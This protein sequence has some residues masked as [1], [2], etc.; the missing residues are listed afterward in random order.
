MARKEK[1]APRKRSPVLD[2]GELAGVIT[3]L[4]E[5]LNATKKLYFSYQGVVK[6]SRTIPDR[7]TQLRAAV[8]LIK[9]HGLYP[10]RGER[11]SGDRYDRSER[12]VINLV[13]HSPDRE[14]NS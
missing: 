4:A 9:L 1:R 7:A 6:C 12:P 8:E 3:G 13:I 2:F 10:K 11:E 5:Q 14:T